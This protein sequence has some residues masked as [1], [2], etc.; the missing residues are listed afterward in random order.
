ML[1]TQNADKAREIIEIFVA[2]I[3]EPLVAYCGR[4]ASRS[5][6]TRP[7]R[8]A[9]AGRRRCPA[10]ADGARRRGDRH[11]RSRRTRASRRRRSPT[12][13]GCS[14]SPTTPG[15]R[16]TRSTAR[17]AS[18]RRAT[19]GEHAT[20]ADNVAKLLRE[21]EGVYPALRTARFATVAI[22]RW[23]DGARARRCG[24]RSRA[25]SRR[26]AAGDE[27]LRLR[28]GVRPDRR[29]RPHVCG[30][31]ARPR[32]MPSRTEAARSRALVARLARP[33]GDAMPLHPSGRARLRHGGGDRASRCSPEERASMTRQAWGLFLAMARCASREPVFAAEDARRRRRAGARLPAVARSRLPCRRASTAAAG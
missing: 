33:G 8:I 25:S 30:D 26:R 29:R 15:S 3:D 28:P 22:A 27:R 18:T 10:L 14:R 13:S 24:A 16:S 19:P 7:D 23:P 12:R 21:L 17:P 6:S 4:P 5:S 2:R 9:G 20:Y 32:N 31:G 1:A 11:A